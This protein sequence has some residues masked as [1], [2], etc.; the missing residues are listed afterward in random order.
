MAHHS[1]LTFYPPT[2]AAAV[3]ERKR[4]Y[5]AGRWKI[6]GR[7]VSFGPDR[8][9]IAR[10]RPA[11]SDPRFRV[12]SAAL[13]LSRHGERIAGTHFWGSAV[14]HPADRRG[15]AANHTLIRDYIFEPATGGPAASVAAQPPLTDVVRFNAMTRVEQASFVAQLRPLLPEEMT[16]ED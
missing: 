9:A 14:W 10:L 15:P 7:N 8:A 3:W 2:D 5:D 16:V 1:W 11:E 12:Q 13:F 6:P 4:A